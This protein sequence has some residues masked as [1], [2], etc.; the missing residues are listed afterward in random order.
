MTDEGTGGKVIAADGH[1]YHKSATANATVAP[2]NTATLEKAS[3]KHLPP[4]VLQIVTIIDYEWNLKG[5]LDLDEL[6]SEYGYSKAELNTYLKDPVCVQ[7]LVERGIT[8]L[9]IAELLGVKPDSKTA[10]L[11]PIQLIAA[12]KMFDVLDTRSNRKKLQDLGVTSSQ[13]MAWMRDETFRNYLKERAEALIG[14]SQHE[15]LLALMDKV[16][17]GDLNAIKYYHEFT[18][19]FVQASARDA[20]INGND[21]QTLVMRIIEI[22]IDEVDDPNQASRISDRLKGLVTGAQVAG[23]LSSPPVEMPKVPETAQGRV[24]TPE[25]KALMDQGVGYDG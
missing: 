25:V 19:R 6:S 16:Q 5:N 3:G 18:G 12:N 24:I 14:D 23:M 9:L 2:T 7:A 22:I 20:G 21:M 11:T 13:Y 10:K 15:A 4:D 1:E 17:A 8:A